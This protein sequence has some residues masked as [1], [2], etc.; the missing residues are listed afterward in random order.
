MRGERREGRGDR[1]EEREERREGGERREERERREEKR[2]SREERRQN[3]PGP[4]FPDWC[5]AWG[6]IFAMY[7]S[8]FR[9]RVRGLASRVFG[10]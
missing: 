10:D 5:R 9:I 4:K 6:V 2:K 3:D 7:V 8:R 1:R